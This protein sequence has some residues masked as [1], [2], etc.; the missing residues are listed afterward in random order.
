MTRH[1][2][3]PPEIVRAPLRTVRARDVTAYAHPRQQLARLAGRGILH[4]LADGF[5]TVVPR[6]RTG[7]TWIPSLEGA[8]AGVAAAEFGDRRYALMNLSA[9]RLHRAVPR[10]LAV[11]D[12]AAPRRRQP[13]R[14]TDRP[15]R[16][17]FFVR[18]IDALHVEMLATDL[19]ACLVTT[20][21]QTVLDLAHLS[22][23]DDL[24]G[25]AVAAIRILLPRCDEANL[26]E[27]AGT[28]RLKRALTRIREMS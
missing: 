4:R 7:D 22:P 13:L 12:V 10:A 3:V 8:A 11:A 27:I 9:A 20:P 19:G 1:P 17:R 18:D 16:V 25:E 6:E 2:G 14:L 5:Y 21:E 26:A 23:L 24:H 28:Q 15:A